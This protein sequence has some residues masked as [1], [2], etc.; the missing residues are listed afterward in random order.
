MFNNLKRALLSLVCL[1]ASYSVMAAGQD[2]VM[3][4]VCD[5]EEQLRVVSFSASIEFPTEKTRTCA[6]ILKTAKEHGFLVSNPVTSDGLVIYTLN[7]ME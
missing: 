7:Y 2:D 6:L 5:A 4:L 3:I 1:G